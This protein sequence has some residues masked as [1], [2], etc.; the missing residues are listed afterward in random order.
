[1][2][3]IE[4]MLSEAD[5]RTTGRVDDVVELVLADPDLFADIFKAILVDNEGVRMRASE[6][7]EKIS[8]IHPEWLVSYK[9]LV[10]NRIS[11]IDQQEVRWH[12]AQIMP[13]LKLRKGE[14]KK[15]FDILIRYL[16]TDSRT[17]KTC[18]LQ[19]LVD[20]AVQERVYLPRVLEL[21]KIYERTG[22]PAIRAR[23]KKLLLMLERVKTRNT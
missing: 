17:L 13:R 7:A 14:R 4:A 6:V 23:S 18:A 20:I 2:T 1:M 5:L 15:V 9:D 3:T 12:M 11:R 22:S 8:R 21:L 19:A 16:N 10:I